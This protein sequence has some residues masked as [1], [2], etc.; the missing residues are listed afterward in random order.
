MIDLL[1]FTA[2]IIGLYLARIWIG[3]R[4]QGISLLITG[5]KSTGIKIYSLI[6]L[7]GVIIHELSH[8]FTAALLN[9]RTGNITIFP[10]EKKEGEISL[11]SVQMAE[12]DFI[13]TSLIG[14]APFF[15]GL[16]AIYALVKLQFAYL[17]DQPDIYSWVNQFITNTTKLSQPITWLTLYAILAIA[18]TMY[19]SKE[20]RRAWPVISF[21]LLLF[22]G[23]VILSGNSRTIA[24]K[25]IPTLANLARSL[26]LSF[27]FA[28]VIDLIAIILLLFLE[29]LLQKL[30]SKRIRYY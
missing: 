18:N 11:G 24:Q 27:I 1:I 14:A 17:L 7:P 28:I 19:T 26:S 12:T 22:L 29:K 30:T 3:S 4:I 6:F 20:D 23:V 16:I 21:F 5:K 25:I 13:R 15:T 10:S 9:V 2:T 8:F